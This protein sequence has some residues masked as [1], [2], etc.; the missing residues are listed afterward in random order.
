VSANGHGTTAILGGALRVLLLSAAVSTSWISAPAAQDLEPRAYSA[1]PV[2]LNFLVVSAARSTGG[3]LVDPSLPITD[4]EATVDLAIVGAGRTINLFGRTALLVGVLPVAWLNASGNVGE[5]TRQVSRSGLAD[6]RIKLSVNLVGG[7]ALTAAEFARTKTRTILGV[8]LTVAPPLGQYERTH[9]VNLGANRWSFKPEVGLSHAVGPWTVEG[10]TG[11]VLFTTND[12]FYTGAAVRTQEPIVT[13]QAHA[14][15]TVR[16]RLW[17][18]FDSTWYAGGRTSVDG[19][20]KADFQRNSRLGA[21]VSLPLWPRQSL[22]IAASTGAT[23]RIGSDFR[24]IAV[25][26]QLTWLDR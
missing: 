16:P 19:V 14:S 1:S 8:S 4:V 13:L 25:A 20:A 12:E 5:D 21:T 2:G 17:A 26:W 3:V 24:T 7:R 23:T 6:P 9:L 11:I 10:Y 18:A 22:K 15:Y